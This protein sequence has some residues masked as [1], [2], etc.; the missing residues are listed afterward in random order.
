[1][2]KELEK[3]GAHI[4]GIKDMSGLLKPMAAN[5]LIKALKN[6]IGI[7][8]HLHT[9]DTSGNGIATVLMAA[10]ADVDIVDAAFNSMSG[11]T[12][13]PALNSVV[14]AMENTG[15]DTGLNL[16]DLQGISDYWDAV[17]PV[18]G[19]FESGL[20][21]GTAEIYKY[22]IPGGQYSNLKPQVE[23]F[24]L[25]HKF[26]EVKEMYKS[27]NEMFGDIVKV[28]PSSKAV[29]DLAI[30]MI[31][32]E[33]NAE[34]IYEKAKDMDFPDSSVAYFQGM[35]GQPMGGFPEELRSLVLKGKETIYKRPGELLPDEDFDKIKLHLD[36]KFSMDSDEKDGLSYALYPKV[37]EDY[38]KY[39]GDTGE[40]KLMG[41]DIYFHGLTE[42]E[43]CEVKIDEGKILVIKLIEVR[44]ISD[45]GFRDIVFELNG[46]RRVINIKDESAKS[47]ANGV[48]KQMADE[49]IPGEIGANIPG[50]I[51]K[52]LVSEG[53]QVDAKT[54]I[55]V[56]EAMKM[57]TNILS[58]VA[59]VVIDMHVKE[60]QQVEA[61][62]LIAVVE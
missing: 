51:I 25:G 40:F 52:V 9:H 43:T 1:M 16:D 59:G 17:R 54:P 14:A 45:D 7:P 13:Q 58:P 57:E 62:E 8:I 53:D 60:G 36:E 15:R 48:A 38:L 20:K 46:N 19:N 56:I 3:S 42:G 5:K 61:G 12:S 27:V 21:S 18:Y 35:M 50:T 34:N 24:G 41:S 47:V 6:E 4:L 32:N 11:L 29:G 23:S 49:E 31:Q 44:K 55:A 37:Y 30:F 33:L 28:T 22:E 2:A 10:I 26:Q 39:I